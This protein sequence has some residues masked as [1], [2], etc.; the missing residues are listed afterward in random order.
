MSQCGLGSSSRTSF[1]LREAFGVSGP[2][3]HQL[4]KVIREGALAL[5]GL[6]GRRSGSTS[7]SQGGGVV[8]AVT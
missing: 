4:V 2:V 6:R 5:L 1:S 7:L 3:I 8:L